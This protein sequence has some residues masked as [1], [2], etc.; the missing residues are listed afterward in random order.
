MNEGPTIFRNSPTLSLLGIGWAAKSGLLN[1]SLVFGT[2][3]SAGRPSGVTSLEMS[4]SVMGHSTRCSEGPL[5]R[6]LPL[7][8]GF[9][10]KVIEEESQ[11][12][13]RLEREVEGYPRNERGSVAGE[14]E[15]YQGPRKYYYDPCNI[16]N[17]LCADCLY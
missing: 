16:L 12:A 15:V 11:L 7:I 4:P 10:P 17:L 6:C 13:K 5:W 8:G 1:W 14:D 9:G 3:W 2:Q